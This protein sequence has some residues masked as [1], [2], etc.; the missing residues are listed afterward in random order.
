[1]NM[2]VA[3]SS[4]THICIVVISEACLGSMGH[5][6]QGLAAHRRLPVHGSHKRACCKLTDASVAVCVLRCRLLPAEE[7]ERL[8]RLCK[9]LIDQGRLEYLQRRGFR[10]ALQRYADPGVSLE[11]VLLTALPARAPPADA[12]A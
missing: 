7:K 1:M 9:L 6:A 4:E 3:V 5:G 2:C 8:G 11:N 10:A 12:T